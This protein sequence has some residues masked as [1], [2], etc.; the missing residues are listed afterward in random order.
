MPQH[1]SNRPRCLCRV[2]CNRPT[3]S[4]PLNPK[5]AWKSPR[6]M[7]GCDQLPSGL[8][9]LCGRGRPWLAE[10]RALFSSRTEPCGDLGTM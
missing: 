9:Q 8:W 10:V 4:Y 1:G 5:V 3:S 6:G 7:S 2:M